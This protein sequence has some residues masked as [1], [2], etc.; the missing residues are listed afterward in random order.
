MKDLR[1]I[2]DYSYLME[3]GGPI[4]EDNNEERDWHI[5]RLGR[6]TGSIL[7]DLVKKD[8]KGGYKLSE[9]KVA[10]D[11]LYK[12]AWE[13][14]LTGES[15]GLNRLNFSS[16]ATEHGHEFEYAAMMKFQE[17]TG[18]Q[19]TPLAYT[20]FEDGE[21][22]GGT[23]DAFTSDEGVLE[24]KS[25]WNGG[26]HLRTLLTGEMY[27]PKHYYQVQGYL[28]LT[29]RPHAW[30]CTYDPDM[31]EGLNLAYIKV[32]RDEEVI[33]AIDA[34]VS[35]CRQIIEEIIEKAKKH[36]AKSK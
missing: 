20:F 15:N 35:E 32:E 11:L 19:V 10:Q 28:K 16:R 7:G 29:G 8:P 33:Q 9:S 24:T 2:N 5:K 14:F 31:P 18:L 12:L 36:E 22:F 30:Y 4:I 3:V 27:E 6:V 23:P 26:N 17:V 1:E 25:P 21:Y 34:I 13:R